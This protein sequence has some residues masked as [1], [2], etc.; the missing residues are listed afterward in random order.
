VAVVHLY[1]HNLLLLAKKSI[2]NKDWCNKNRTGLLCHAISPVVHL[3]LHNL[4]LLSKKSVANKDWRNKDRTGLLC[5]AIS[6]LAPSSGFLTITQL[7]RI[8]MFSWKILTIP[9]SNLDNTLTSRHYIFFLNENSTGF[10]S[11]FS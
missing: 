5:H 2:A 3:Y 1:L 8:E 7:C 4:L 11:S 9:S 10:H 6:P